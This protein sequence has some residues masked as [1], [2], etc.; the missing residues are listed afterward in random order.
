MKRIIQKQKHSALINCVGAETQN[1][2]EGDAMITKENNLG[3][4]VYG[5]DCAMVGFWNKEMIGVCHAGWR[6]YTLELVCKMAKIFSGGNCY[7][8][9]FMHKFEVQKDECF[10]QIKAYCGEKYFLV[11]N[12]KIFFDFKSAILAELDG[13][14]IELDDRSTFDYPELGSW[15][16]DRKRGNGTQNCLVVCRKND[17]VEKQ[18][19][20]PG[21]LIN[22]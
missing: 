1:W 18:L 7:L 10:D 19:F 16:R 5:A 14:S 4:V 21:E 12:S 3:L 2:I 17:I 8:A 6:G 13:L 15:R 20:L 9:P 11:E 22:V